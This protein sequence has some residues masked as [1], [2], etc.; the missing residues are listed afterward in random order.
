MKFTTVGILFP[1]T[2]LIAQ[3]DEQNLLPSTTITG[4][5]QSILPDINSAQEQVTLTPGGASVI[6]PENWT[7][8]YVRYEDIFQF[9]PGVYA[10][11]SVSDHDSRIS[12]RGSGIQRQF[13]LRGISLLVNGS[14]ANN[15]DGSFQFRVIDPLSIG[16]I[17]TYR[18]ANG[19]PY[20]GSQ[21]GGAINVVQ[22]NGLTDPGT[23]I[24][25]QY[26][27]Y[28]SYSASLQHGGSKDKWDWFFLYSVNESEGFRPHADVESQHITANLGYQW[29]DT[30]QTRFH[31][32]FNDTDAL[33]SGGLTSAQ[34][35]DDIRTQ[36][37]FD[38]NDHDI[39]G[40]RFG[41]T[42][43]W[44]TRKGEWAF[45]ANYQYVDLDHLT[46]FANQ[47]FPGFPSIDNLIDND[48]DEFSLNLRGK[49]DYKLFGL[50]HTFRTNLDYVY[51]VNEAGGS[52]GFGAVGIVDRKETSQNVNV[53]FEN[54]TYLNSK[55]SLTY[56]VGYTDSSREREIRGNDTTGLPDFDESQ[57]GVTWRAGYLYEHN[58]KTQFYAN[59]SRSFESAPISEVSSNIADPQFAT[60]FEIG[61]RFEHN[62]L[63]GEVTL[64][65]SN[66][67]DEFVF[68]EVAVNSNVFNITNADT[69]RFGI[70]AT[71]SIDLNEALSLGI[72]QN[73]TWDTSY[74]Y[75]DFTFDGGPADGNQIPVIAE[76]VVSS[77]LTL[78]DENRKWSTSVSV[79][80]LPS[81][82]FSDNNN[83]LSVP[84]YAV[85]DLYGEYQIN[86]SLKVYG[87]VN[88]V[89]DRE[90]AA[91]VQVNASGNENANFI[92]PGSGRAGFIGFAY[93]F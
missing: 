85:F 67:K 61:T 23:S 29:S 31:F 32:M 80:W 45:S 18:G 35:Q 26:G 84:G 90:F 13:G 19:L 71:A 81:D 34:F 58:D 54:Q 57:N 65:K 47:I 5:A 11:N 70:E 43:G 7:G 55:N 93:Q 39:S 79:D 62:W 50:D 28:E 72:G 52:S 14:I 38:G 15:A 30:T 48:T 49:E 20:G 6:T 75:N 88:N 66:V 64:F 68:E 91:T 3:A 8:E 77:R 69:D 12:V 16:Y 37:N 59:V 76:N 83:T 2:T 17:E 87:G 92:F 42:T 36:I 82:L 86:K 21:L 73:L 4:D 44:E 40:I 1:I 10:R 56:G 25:A 22:K 41:Q 60:T 27:S 63:K 46:T 9:E 74:Q 33:L 78:S 24:T 51:G 53:Y 89:L